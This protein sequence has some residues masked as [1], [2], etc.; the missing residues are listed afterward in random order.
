MQRYLTVR[1]VC[2]RTTIGQSKLYEIMAAGELPYIKVDDRRMIGES[3]LENFMQA[4]RST[5][6]PRQLEFAATRR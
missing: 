5:P 1:E 3:D 2:E 6:A 4:R